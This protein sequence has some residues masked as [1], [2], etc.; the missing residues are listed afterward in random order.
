MRKL[1][2]S[3]GA[4][5]RS[6]YFSTDCRHLNFELSFEEGFDEARK[7]LDQ[8]STREELERLCAESRAKQVML[9]L[10]SLIA[11]CTRQRHAASDVLPCGVGA[12]ARL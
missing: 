9:A 8:T 11:R 7:W 1:V 4:V 10:R 6:G 2:Q 3:Q 12:C 5:A